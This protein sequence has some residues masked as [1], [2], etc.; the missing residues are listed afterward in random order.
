VKKTHQVET[1]SIADNRANGEAAVPYIRPAE[2]TMRRASPLPRRGDFST[3]NH[4]RHQSPNSNC[5]IT[6]RCTEHGH[7][8]SQPKPRGYKRSVDAPSSP[9]PRLAQL[10]THLA[11]HIE[12][13]CLTRLPVQT[14]RPMAAPAPTPRAAAL[15]LRRASKPLEVVM[16]SKH[17]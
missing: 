8:S 12:S 4:W 10:T 16:A 9:S 2:T 11:H 15:S 5:R 14:S 7:Q 3:R 17:L 13:T 1:A 6:Q